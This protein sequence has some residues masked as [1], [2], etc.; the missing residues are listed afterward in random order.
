MTNSWDQW[1]PDRTISCRGLPRIGALVGL[2]NRAWRVTA[3]EPLP[4][5]DWT[6]EQQALVEHH[7]ITAV[8]RA[9]LLQPIQPGG[10]EAGPCE[11]YI[12]HEGTRWDVYIDEHIPYCGH[13]L[14]PTPCRERYAAELARRAM[15]RLERYE[16]PGVCP[17][18]WEPV[19]QR[20]KCITFDENIELSGG[21]PV[22]FHARARCRGEAIDY[23]R[24]WVSA[25]PE[26]RHPP[27]TARAGW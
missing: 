4:R 13:C 7:G 24:R 25:D 21:P 2:D 26:H 15:S 10:Q 20:Q 23:E 9:V 5:E 11:R 3:V 16:T 18:C 14:E 27:S 8:P 22:T 1:H 17:A 12:A 6:A 19:T